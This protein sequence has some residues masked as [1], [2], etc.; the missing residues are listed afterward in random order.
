MWRTLLKFIVAGLL[1]LAP[2]WAMAE[3]IRIAGA[4]N[5]ADTLK[6][7]S[8]LFEKQT[9]HKISVSSGSS[10]S[11]Y[12]M[13]INGAPFD[14]FF[15][16]DVERPR[17]LEEAGAI[18]PGSRFTYALGRLV[19][20]SSEDGVVDPEGRILERGDYKRLAIANPKLAPYGK[21]AQEVL[22]ARGVWT[23]IQHRV[24][25]GESISQTFQFVHTGNAQLGFVAL[26][27]L[28]R[29]GKGVQ[30]SHWTV[31]RNLYAP[32]EQQAVLLKDNDTARAFL[33]FVQSTE[34]RQLIQVYG[35]DVR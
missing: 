32:I 23:K 18:I 31:P 29:P 28:S 22:E 6:D 12:A 35:Y 26:S 17:L 7:I 8:V 20:W 34:I 27:Q 13:I 11:H 16:A 30:G 3:E 21:A 24:V 14:A 25:R 4:S 9:G 1:L 2:G 15:S 5:F 33:A 19:L 10:G